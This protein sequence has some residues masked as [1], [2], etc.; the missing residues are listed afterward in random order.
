[1]ALLAIILISR[2]CLRSHYPSDVV[3]SILLAISWWKFSQVLYVKYYDL[4]KTT[5]EEHIL[6][7][8]N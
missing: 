6:K 2:I 3:G 8:A 5:I 1:M 7:R 4:A